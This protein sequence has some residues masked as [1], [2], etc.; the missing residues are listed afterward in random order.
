MK[1]SS[2]A[3]RLFVLVSLL[4]TVDLVAQQR[5]Q[6]TTSRIH[7]SPEPPLPYVVERV[8]PELTLVRP[9]DLLPLPGSSR[10]IVVEEGGRISSFEPSPEV[11]H[12]ELMADLKEFDREISRV[13]AVALHPNFSQNRLIFVRVTLDGRGQRNVEN[14]ARI[15]RFR[16][17][18][19]AVPR[20][21]MK[22]GVVVFAWLSG[23][24]EGGNMRF[25]PDGMLYITTGDADNPDPPDSFVTGQDIAMFSQAFCELMWTARKWGSC[26]PFQRTTRLSR[27]PRRAAKSGRMGLGIRGV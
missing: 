20:I 15:L 8:Y 25:G 17:T 9:L 19:D 11:N 12:V 10:L 6:W 5:E 4:S 23:G 2:L 1:T 7:G 27:C 24:H 3:N 26:T 13:Y 16:M 18:T 21:D 22:S 14:G